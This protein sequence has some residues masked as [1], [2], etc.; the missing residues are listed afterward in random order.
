MHNLGHIRHPVPAQSS[1]FSRICWNFSKS[2]M[3]VPRFLFYTLWLAHCCSNYYPRSQEIMMLNSCP[4]YLL[5]ASA[6]RK[7]FTLGEFWVRSNKKNMQAGFPWEPGNHQTGGNF[8]KMELWRSFSPGLPPPVAARLV[9]TV[10]VLLV[11]RATF[12]LDSSYIQATF[13]GW[14]WSMLKASKPIVFT[15]IQMFSE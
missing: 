9:S 7:A 14:E 13:K 1:R 8:M 12:K 11:F 3:V 2:F 4:W 15:E 10:T 5:T 6:G